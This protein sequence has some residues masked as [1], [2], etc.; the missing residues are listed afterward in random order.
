MGA[1][2]NSQ[3]DVANKGMQVKAG[4]RTPARVSGYDGPVQTGTVADA[5]ML[6]NIDFLGHIL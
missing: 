6:K 3:K 5:K 2:A 4:G 1:D